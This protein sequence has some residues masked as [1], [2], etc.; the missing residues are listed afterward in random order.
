M[1][2]PTSSFPDLQLAGVRKSKGRSLPHWE[3]AGAIYHVSLHLADSVPKS[4]L[5]EWMALKNDIAERAKGE[6]RD[7]TDGERSRMFDFYAQ[8]IEKYLSSGYGACLLRQKDVATS[9]A[10]CICHDNGVLY[11]IHEYCIMP[12][13]VHVI[14]GGLLEDCDIMQV[15]STWKRISGHAVNRAAGRS[16]AVWMRDAYTRIIR[17]EREYSRQ[18]AYV[19]NNP[20][21]AGL[22]DGFLR[23]R[24]FT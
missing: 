3:A 24:F 7:V 13:H 20:E 18:L 23:E 5:E 1:L 16:G 19:W 22:Q 2:K 6:Q 17:D 12:N 9:V 10:N 14:V 11:A 4:Q 21:S 15:V 8:R